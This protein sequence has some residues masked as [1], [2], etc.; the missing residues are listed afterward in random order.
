LKRREYDR[1]LP[2]QV[3]GLTGS[4]VRDQ[5]DVRRDRAEP[6][7]RDRL[8]PHKLHG[9]CRRGELPD[10]AAIDE[11]DDTHRI[12]CHRR[13]LPAS[14]R[15]HTPLGTS[16]GEHLPTWKIL[17]R[18]TETLYYHSGRHSRYRLGD[19]RRERKGLVRLS[20]SRL[21]HWL[22]WG[23]AHPE[24]VQ[25][26][27]DGHHQITDACFPQA[28][29][30]FHDAAAF[31]TAVD[32]LHPYP[33]SMQGPL[34]PLL[35]SCQLLAARFLGGHEDLDRGQREGQAAQLLQQPTARRER[36]GSG[37]RTAQI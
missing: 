19:F 33:T 3:P 6:G 26:T 20:L 29:A 32:M 25:G 16:P 34:G 22:P 4:R 35:L 15:L 31:D 9:G 17:P 14:L 37:L 13:F 12:G 30:V 5:V 36:V 10:L 23:Q 1:F 2:A 18:G 8:T 24:V 27:A 28:D 7:G 11:Q 21:N